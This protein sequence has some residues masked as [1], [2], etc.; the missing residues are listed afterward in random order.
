MRRSCLAWLILF[1]AG[2]ILSV[3]AKAETIYHSFSFDA[4]MISHEIITTPTGENFT[5]IVWE[6]MGHTQEPGQPEL[7]VLYVNFLV[8]SFTNNYLVTVTNQSLGDYISLDELPYPVQDYYD[9][10]D[11]EVFTPPNGSEYT[12][13]EYEVKTEITG[14]SF[15]DGNVKI[16][17][18]AI[19]PCFYNPDNHSLSTFSDVDVELSYDFCTREEAGIST[20][21]SMKNRLDLHLEDL[22]VNTEDIPSDYNESPAAVS[23]VAGY[24]YIITPQKLVSA[25]DDLATWKRQKGYAVTVKS[26][27][28]IVTDSRFSPTK[29]PGREDSAASIRAYLM[30]E[31]RNNPEGIPMYCLLAGHLKDNFPVRWIR[32]TVYDPSD[33]DNFNKGTEIYIPTDVYFSDLINDWNLVEEDKSGIFTNHLDSITISFTLPVGRLMCRTAEEVA[34]Y[35]KKL[36][37]YE[38]NPGYGDNNY[39]NGA[40]S[41]D[42]AELLKRNYPKIYSMISECYSDTLFYED[43]TEEQGYL[44][45]SGE[46]VISKMKGYGLHLWHGHGNPGSILIHGSQTVKSGDD[47]EYIS[48]LSYYGKEEI[49]KPYKNQKNGLDNLMNYGKPAVAY[50]VACSITPFD[51]YTDTDTS[52][53]DPIVNAGSTE[54]HTY[55]IKYNMGESYTLGGLNGG[56]ALF[57]CTRPNLTAEGRKLEVFFAEALKSNI[58]KAGDLERKIKLNYK[59]NTNSLPE[60][61]KLLHSHSLIGEPEFEIWIGKPKQLDFNFENDLTKVYF[62]NNDSKIFNTSIFNGISSD[63][64]SFSSSGFLKLPD[65]GSNVVSVWETGHLPLVRFIGINSQIRNETKSFISRDAVISNGINNYIIEDN[66]LLHLRALDKIVTNKGF[67][68]RNSG[69]ADLKCDKAVELNGTIIKNGGKM[70]VEAEELTLGAGF[71]VEAGGEFEFVPIKT[72]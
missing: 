41:F 25:F 9:T 30:S 19:R 23:D 26:L 27:E 4:S 11:N 1:F 62:R 63:F 53:S 47:M 50:A 31:D 58:L 17:T 2:T 18:V 54:P 13:A 35:T 32:T 56:V 69:M 45:P 42:H 12:Q 22:V 8:P 72:R 57:G 40:F 49:N 51:T 67:E 33:R 65:S 28:S 20:D 6:G 48:A 46:T 16:V 44:G 68:I 52:A 14:N 29:R 7:P 61:I 43:I 5:K 64:R 37:L 55:D 66:G 36:I 15:L 38:S 34:N 3:T 21:A 70:T 59:N 71:E 10:T 60:Q 39:L 24:Y